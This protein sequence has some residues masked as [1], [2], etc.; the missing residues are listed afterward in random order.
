M[1]RV[2]CRFKILVGVV[3]PRSEYDMNI[4][5]QTENKTTALIVL[6]KR[7]FSHKPTNRLIDFE[8]WSEV[9]Q[10]AKIEIGFQ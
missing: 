2:V 6:M 5:S 4:E 9:K 1:V 8:Y 3:L 7:S 10:C